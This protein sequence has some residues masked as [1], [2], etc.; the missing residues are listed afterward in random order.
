MRFH[1][2]QPP[3]PLLSR[4]QQWRL[5]LMVVML[6]FV[7][8]AIRSSSKPE[9]WRW[10]FELTGQPIEPEQPRLD[11][12]D[13]KVQTD[14]GP[15]PPEVFRSEIEPDAAPDANVAPAPGDAATELPPGLLNHLRDNHLG[16][17][18]AEEP[19]IDTVIDTVRRLTPQQMEAAALHDVAFTV[20]MVNAAQYRGRI[21]A[22]RGTLR[23]FDLYDAGDPDDPADDLFEAWLFSEDSGN[24]PYRVLVTAAP[25]SLSPGDRLNVSV[26]THAYFI[27]RYGYVSQGGTHVAPLLIGKTLHVLPPPPA[28]V[29]APGRDI[30]RVA[31]G[32]L[33][34]LGALFA[35][36][37]GWLL[38]GDRR[39]RS[40]RV[41]ELAAERL[42]ARAEDLE[43][44][45]Q[46]DVVDPGTMLR[47]MGEQQAEPE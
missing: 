31:L 12:L 44:L 33:L 24:N 18:R 19:A 2:R 28:A 38:W 1:H 23:K 37:S 11:T 17:L 45:K 15:L 35:A 34:A 46:A 5:F 3:P 10:F 9:N 26:L 29:P 43:A 4:P 25:P 16:N 40:R 7:I 36:V 22:L 30:G 21:I 6:I 13:F 41:D 42:A 47:R 8:Y 39:L 20:L 27:K 14:D 32:A